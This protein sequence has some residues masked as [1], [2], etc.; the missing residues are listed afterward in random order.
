MNKLLLLTALSICSLSLCT[1][2]QETVEWTFDEKGRSAL[3]LAITDLDNRLYV[4]GESGGGSE[5][6]QRI[7][8]EHVAKF[9]ALL[10]KPGAPINNLKS[11]MSPLMMA[12]YCHQWEII[13]FLIKAGADVR[14]TN[15][16]G[17][18]ALHYVGLTTWAPAPS[19][20]FITIMIMQ[21][22]YTQERHNKC[23][24]LLAGNMFSRMFYK[25][26]YAAAQSSLR[27]LH[28]PWWFYLRRLCVNSFKK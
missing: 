26:R 16:E 23:V 22:Y 19:I 2:E 8:R 24:E 4:Q 6:Y 13:E 3:E 10:Q 25:R 18:T 21:E 7:I 5:N 12:A 28:E 14:L 17:A 15:A 9:E 1:V 11:G 20:R 27:L